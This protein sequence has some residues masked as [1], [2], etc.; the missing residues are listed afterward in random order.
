MIPKLS[1]SDGDRLFARLMAMATRSMREAPARRWISPRDLSG[2]FGPGLARD[3]GSALIY[4]L[5]T[6]VN[7]LR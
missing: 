6:K 1:R 2:F 3:S 4:E 7:I 5:T